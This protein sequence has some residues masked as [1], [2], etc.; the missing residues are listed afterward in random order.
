MSNQQPMA[1]LIGQQRRIR[2]LHR[3]WSAKGKL[4]IL[5]EDDEHLKDF[6]D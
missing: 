4:I 6:K 5:V 2:K 3:P 1:K